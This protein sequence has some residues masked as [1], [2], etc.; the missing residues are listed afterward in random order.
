MASVILSILKTRETT[1]FQDVADA[2]VTHLGSEVTDL[3]SERTVRRRVYDVLNVFV[4]AGFI[5]KD[6]KRIICNRTADSRVPSRSESIREKIESRQ[7]ALADKVR[8]LVGWRLVIERNRKLQR[9]SKAVPLLQTLFVGFAHCRGG[10]YDQ[11]LDGRSVAIHAESPPLFFSP[12][13]VIG[14]MGFTLQQQLA[15]LSDFPELQTM[16]PALFPKRDED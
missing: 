8:L 10:G 4:A 12:T 15:V 6:G 3:N 2:I 13:E 11:G 7:T 16:V 9:P 14:K 5:Q 1:T